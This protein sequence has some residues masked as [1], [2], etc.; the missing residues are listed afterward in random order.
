M[1]ATEVT[2]NNGTNSLTIYAIDVEEVINKSLTPFTPPN[3][4]YPEGPKDTLILDL[5]IIERRF[6]VKGKIE[7]SDRLTLLAIVDDGGT[8]SFGYNGSTYVVNFE[9]IAIREV[10]EDKTTVEPEFYDVTLTFIEGI[11]L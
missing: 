10:P 4:N 6:T 9:K 5:L 1:T 8:F 7:S 3:P 11:S 2:L